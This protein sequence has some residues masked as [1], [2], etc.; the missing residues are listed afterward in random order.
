MANVHI[1]NLPDEVYRAIQLQ[2]SQHGRST[3]AEIHAIL[4]MAVM[5]ENR[6]KLGTLLASIA[7]EAGPL[8]D[9]EHALFEQGPMEP[10]RVSMQGADRIM[11]ALYNPIP[12]N[13][14]L[15][16]AASGHRK[17]AS[18]FEDKKN[19]KDGT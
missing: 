14:K 4:E 8:T 17:T 16:S 7:R 18:D 10:I 9:E 19:N 5:R 1:R 13:A 15:R 6:Q 11:A 12:A 3:E 2:A